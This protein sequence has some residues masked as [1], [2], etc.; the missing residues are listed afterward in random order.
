MAQEKKQNLSKGVIV[1]LLGSSALMIP[2]VKL[3][4]GGAVL[5]EEQ[6]G[7][8]AHSIV[9]VVLALILFG[10][11]Y[12]WFKV[13]DSGCSKIRIQKKS[14]LKG[15]GSGLMA[16][17]LYLFTKTLID[18]YKSIEAGEIY[19]TIGGHIMLWFVIAVC[20]ISALSTLFCYLD[21]AKAMETVNEVQQEMAELNSLLKE[22]GYSS[23]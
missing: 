1:A 19:Y 21:S 22:M 18:I 8:I 16:S 20:L 11:S 12:I 14:L 10:I 3:A 4:T 5:L 6:Y 2:V 15:L 13:T 17:S 7:V 23:N 9:W